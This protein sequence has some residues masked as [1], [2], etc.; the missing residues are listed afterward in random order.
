M[1]GPGSLLLAQD[2][3]GSP[4]GKR[5]FAVG[6]ETVDLPPAAVPD[7]LVGAYADLLRERQHH[8][9]LWSW[10]LRTGVQPPPE[11]APRGA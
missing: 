6:G 4:T 7:V 9:D 10:C 1:P 5:R 11:L 8:E 2:L 3:G